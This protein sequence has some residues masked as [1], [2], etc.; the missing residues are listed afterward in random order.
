M[1]VVLRAI[2]GHRDTGFTDCP[3]NALYAQLP[4]IAREVSLTGGPKLYAPEVNG[5]LGGPIRFGGTLS[6]EEQWTVTITGPGGATVATQ[7]GTGPTLDWVWDSSAAAPGPYSW[8]ISGPSLRGASGSLGTKAATAL[9]FE[10]P[11]AAPAVVSPGGDPA[12]DAATIGYTLTQ[13]AT[14]TATLVGPSGTAAT[15]FS[16][17]QAAGAQTLTY[18]VPAT[19][20]PGTYQV[21]LEA[22]GAAGTTA[23]ASAFFLVDPTL[24]SFAA[25]PAALSLAR[26]AGLTVAFTLAAGPVQAQVDILR[27]DEVVATPAEGTYQAGA[28]TVT[29]DG[30][31]PD[32]TKAPDGS[33]TVR[34][35]LTDSVATFVRSAPLTVD[36]TPPGLAVVSARTMRFR[37][38][39]AARVTLVVGNR[40]FTSNRRAGPLQFWLKKRPFAYRVVVTDGAGNRFA[41]LYRTR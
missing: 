24:A 1:P 40:R 8:S 32:G 28:Q 21:T 23:S 6:G 15:V 7:S 31:L 22:V 33:Y 17:P 9:A 34:L 29:W 11:T 39:E 26:P 13:P 41:K 3:G 27:G 10:S 25:S 14:V 35:T 2:S 36:S 37:L 30:T 38:S 4:E 12:D 20:P 19:S 5:K 18:T 16:G